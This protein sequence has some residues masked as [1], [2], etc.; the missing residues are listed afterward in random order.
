MAFTE[1]IVNPALASDTGLGTLASPYGD[2]E[3]AI[4]QEVFDTANGTRISVMTGVDEILT[5]PLQVAMADFATTAAWVP[6]EAFPCVIEGMLAIPGDLRGLPVTAGISGGGLV[7]IMNDSILD[8][9]KFQNLH[10]HNV[11]NNEILDLDEHVAIIRCELSNWTGNNQAVNVDSGILTDSYIHSNGGNATAI[12][13]GTNA[14]HI[15]RNYLDL[16]ATVISAMSLANGV[17]ALHNIV[18]LPA[19]DDANGI[20]VDANAICEHN[21]I[22]SRGGGTGEAIKSTGSDITGYIQNNIVQGF[23]GVGGLAFDFTAVNSG[24]QVFRGNAYFDCTTG[25]SGPTNWPPLV[26]IDNEELTVSPFTDPDSGDFSPVDTG[27]V[28]EGALS[29]TIGGGLV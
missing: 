15:L 24:V 6:G 22:Y 9:I 19:S 28:R 1:I 4:K 18:I 20:T 12:L 21:V 3:W 8:S 5:S 23:S 29:Q 13:F 14:G 7:S 26:D 17:S 27:S 25:V 16:D 11:G 2:L 10:L